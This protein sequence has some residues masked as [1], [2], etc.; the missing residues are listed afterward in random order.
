MSPIKKPKA[1][2]NIYTAMLA[3]ATGAVFATL[4]YV[5]ITCL[6]DYGAMLTIVNLSR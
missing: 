1:V 2:N 3:L 6:R 5:L 4:I